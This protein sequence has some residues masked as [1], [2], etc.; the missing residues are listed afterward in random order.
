[1]TMTWRQHKKDSYRGNDFIPSV[2]MPAFCYQL[3]C[4]LFNLVK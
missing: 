1:M 4:K 2:E 3:E